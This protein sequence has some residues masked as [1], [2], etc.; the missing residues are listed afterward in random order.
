[1]GAMECL[2]VSGEAVARTTTLFVS[3]FVV[4]SLGTCSPTTSRGAAL[5][6]LLGE[7]DAAAFMAAARL[8]R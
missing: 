4:V 6:Q 7:A 8:V 3:G 2:L 5:L 1:M